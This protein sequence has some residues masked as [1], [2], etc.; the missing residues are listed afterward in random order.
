MAEIESL[1][2][3][4]PDPARPAR[5]LIEEQERYNHDPTNGFEEY[6]ARHSYNYD[7]GQGQEDQWR[8]DGTN[9]WRCAG[10]AKVRKVKVPEDAQLKKPP[11]KHTVK[12]HNTI[13]STEPIVRPY[14]PKVQTV[15]TNSQ[16]K[17]E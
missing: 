17:E 4:G 6:Q 11:D 9:N 14:G 13:E 10:H 12:I 16:N 5:E 1:L 15:E 2:G 3:Q 8:E 7:Y